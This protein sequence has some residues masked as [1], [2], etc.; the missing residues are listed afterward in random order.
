MGAEKGSTL[1]ILTVRRS[2]IAFF[3]LFVLLVIWPGMLPFNRIQPLVLG[4]PFSMA[5]IA[6]WVVLSFLAL[7]ILDRAETRAR[8]GEGEED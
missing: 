5:W 7:V 1:K 8:R 3:L 6:G 4:L 2:V